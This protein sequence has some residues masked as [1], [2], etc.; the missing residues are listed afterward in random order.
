MDARELVCFFDY[1]SLERG[2]SANTVRA[3]R[4]DLANWRGFCAQ[5]GLD[6]LPFDESKIAR[7]LRYLTAQGKA[8]STLQRN[9]AVFKTYTRFLANEGRDAPEAGRIDLPQKGQQLPQIL[10]EGEV[11]RLLGACDESKALGLRDRALLELAY[12]C[13]L[14][15]SELCSL[16]LGDLD[17]TAG[18]L[19]TRGKGDKERQIP[20]LGEVRQIL[21]RYVDEAR[22]ALSRKNPIEPRELFLSRTG[23]PLE[24]SELWRI[25]RK[26]GT[27]AG[28][29]KTRL[30][31]HALRHSF[32][33]HLLRRGMDL[34]TLQELLGH[35][36]IN[37]TQK[38][39]HFDMEIREI[40]DRYHPRA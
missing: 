29:S 4:S 19:R 11:G 37:T 35:A 7:Y 12:G 26:R 1:L 3:Y 30:H 6:P 15:A 34:R 32:A 21:E 36:S 20:Y 17:A 39:T 38:Y 27:A 33:S 8:K 28:I 16:R 24:R 23:R 18:V 10:T 2:C 25:V 22:P 13:G 9:V 5:N 31:P 40:Y 14:R